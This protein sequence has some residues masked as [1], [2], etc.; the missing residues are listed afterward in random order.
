MIT[1]IS[2][3]VLITIII[4]IH[5]FGHYS[6]AQIVNIKIL[7]FSIGFGKII[8]QK[9]LGKDKTLFTLRAI[10]LGGFVKPLDKSSINEHE[11]DQLTDEEKNR[12]LNNASKF[13]KI[14][15]VFGGPLFNFILAFFIFFSMYGLLGVTERAAR[16][17]EITP[18]SIIAKSGLKQGQTIESINGNKIYS[19]E[20][21]MNIIANK[22][23]QS[24]DILIS[25]TDKNE[26]FINLSQLNLNDLKDN[27]IELIGIY[28][29]SQNG[30]LVVKELLDGSAKSMG[31]KKGDIFV[32]VN[33]QPISDI[34]QLLRLIRN[35][36]DKKL[37]F[38]IN[39]GGNTKE[40]EVI[41]LKTK[42]GHQYVGKIGVQFDIKDRKELNKKVFGFWDSMTLS[43]QRVYITTYTSLISFKKILTGE[44][45]AKNLSGPITIAEHSGKSAKMGFNA[46]L[47]LMAVISI[48]IGVF[49]LLPIPVLDGGTLLQH[50]I[51]IIRGK[52]FSDK[53]ISRLQTG[54]IAILASVFFITIMNDIIRQL[55]I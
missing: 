35:N 27:L 55:P 2:F 34:G 36:P 45:S 52:D 1:I 31:I 20:Q 40:F 46:F 42:E 41:P 8:F 9:N 3:L 15:M 44:I 11:W 23:I 24:K 18:N 37:N 12:S 7:E 29:E 43:A 26:Y 14:I 19:S 6:M 48:G 4:A 25:T 32:S 17:N 30:T 21:A 16:I 49:N 13:K 22:A 51:E 50:V 28:F 39:R 38:T 53:T 54:G 47:M 10:P 33:N 5:E